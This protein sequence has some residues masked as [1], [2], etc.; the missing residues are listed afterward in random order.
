M[1]SHL[2]PPAPR[3]PTTTPEEY[4]LSY[5]ATVLGP[6]M[7]TADG[8]CWPRIST[9]GFDA[10]PTDGTA[11]HESGWTI[12]VLV[13]ST[14]AAMAPATGPGAPSTSTPP[15]PPPSSPGSSVREY[16]RHVP[17]HHIYVTQG[18]LEY[19][20]DFNA[21]GPRGTVFRAELCEAYYRDGLCE[22]G[23]RC[24]CIHTHSTV[25]AAQLDTVHVNYVIADVKDS[26]YPTLPAGKLLKIYDPNQRNRFVEVQSEHLLRNAGSEGLWRDDGKTSMKPYHCAHFFLRKLCNRGPQCTFMHVATVCSPAPRSTSP[27]AMNSNYLTPTTGGPA[28]NRPSPRSTSLAASLEDP[29]VL[30]VSRHDPY[31]FERSTVVL[32]HTP[33][34]SL[35]SSPAAGNTPAGS[36][37]ASNNPNDGT[38]MMT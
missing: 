31:S 32:K 15:P 4:K 17:S 16:V 18:S 21:C 12:P 30:E 26:V 24:D 1:S 33:T 6:S 27:S 5:R 25:V 22:Q 9:E 13:S 36:R 34:F 3:S 10:L 8:Y 28:S 29:N 19:I 2:M 23:F 7:S 20:A 14:T 35:S 38:H 37:R 11:M